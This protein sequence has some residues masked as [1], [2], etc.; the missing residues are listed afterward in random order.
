MPEKFVF[1]GYPSAYLFKEAN[2]KSTILHQFLWGDTLE[3]L[4]QEQGGFV[5]VSGRGSRGWVKKDQAQDRQLLDIIFVDVGQG[6]SCLVV[7]P[8][9]ERFIIDAGLE[10][11]MHRYLKW[12]YKT[13]KDGVDIKA[14]FISHPDSDHYEGFRDIFADS[15]YKIKTVYHNGLVERK[16]KGLAA[17]G[18]VIKSGDR[19]WI[20]DLITDRPA[21]ERFLAREDE[22][23]GKKYAELLAA[24]LKKNPAGDVR[25]LSHTQGY[26]PGYEEYKDLSVQV[27]GPV[28]EDK[29]GR[30]TLRSYG[31][32]G[33]TKNGN[34]IILSVKY[35]RVRILLGGDLN[36]PSEEFL[37]GHFAAG[38][39]GNIFQ[40]DVLKAYH[41][42]S[43][44]FS[45][46]FLRA[47]QPVV[48]VISSGDNE[49]YSHPRADA[50][51]A[52]GRW[53]RSARPLIFCTELARSARDIVK[54]PFV[55]RA[56]YRMLNQTIQDPA[57]PKKQREA[58]EKKRDLLEKKLIN[59]SIAVFG[60]INLR[61]DGEKVVMAQK[62]EKPKADKRWDIYELEPD[63]ANNNL[64]TFRKGGAS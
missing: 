44:D 21:L 16:G 29:D 17:L 54:H 40:S 19:S 1:A 49:D 31:D 11:N 22:W 4:G 47:I 33:K 51:G 55:L 8:Q 30:P 42:G 45:E 20:G 50:L 15:L 32:V 24:F 13:F 39:S 2:E 59:R 34:S 5:N 28:V 64:L 3:H 7:T 23:Q 14:T 37:L 9:D 6:D 38:G 35:H 61:T 43:G 53:S 41:H 18:T 58:A 52:L 46:D 36:I 56:E 63:P 26:L 62:L 25:M 27:L 10:D 12:R 60:A 48:T 57:T